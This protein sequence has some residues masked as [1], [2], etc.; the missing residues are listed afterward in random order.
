M[1][2]TARSSQSASSTELPTVPLGGTRAESL[3]RLQFGLSGVVG[4]ILLVGLAT[5]IQ[6]RAKEVE[7]ASVPDAAATTEPSPPAERQDPLAEAGVVPE[8]S[9]SPTP[10]Q[11]VTARQTDLPAPGRTASP[12]VER[13]PGNP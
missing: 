3:R 8:M 4:V 9:A 12:V 11:A 7:Q 1:A 5:I 10:T 6:D 2:D 13:T